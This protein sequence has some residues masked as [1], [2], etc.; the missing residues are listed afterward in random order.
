M[1]RSHAEWEEV[2]KEADGGDEVGALSD[3]TA[4]TASISSGSGSEEEAGS[5]EGLEGEEGEGEGQG[6]AEFT[7]RC[8]TKAELLAL[9]LAWGKEA[10]AVDLHLHLDGRPFKVPAWA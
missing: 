5:G 2:G 4:G 3:R 8:I 7:A 9:G 10:L 1:Q 6:S